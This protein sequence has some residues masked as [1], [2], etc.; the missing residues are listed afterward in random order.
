MIISPLFRVKLVHHL[1]DGSSYICCALAYSAT[2]IELDSFRSVKRSHVIVV[3]LH[4]TQRNHPLVIFLCCALPFTAMSA[5]AFSIVVWSFLWSVM[6]SIKRYWL[7]HV[8]HCEYIFWAMMFAVNSF[9]V[10]SGNSTS[11]TLVSRMGFKYD[12]PILFPRSSSLRRLTFT[13]C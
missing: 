11:Y 10:T 3:S 1:N 13:V 4:C 12:F 9:S 8:S 2:S 6:D 7:P 5:S